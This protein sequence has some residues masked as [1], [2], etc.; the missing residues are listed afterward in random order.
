VV[1]AGTSAGLGRAIAQEFADRG[2]RLGLIARGR[3]WLEDVRRD[4]EA[5]AGGAPV[6]PTDVADAGAVARAAERVER[7]LGPIDRRLAA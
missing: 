5:R 6:L 1:V 2:A 7:E 4:V 3:E